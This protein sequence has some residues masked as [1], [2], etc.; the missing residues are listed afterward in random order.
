MKRLI[1]YVKECL[2]NTKHGERYLISFPAFIF[3]D[4]A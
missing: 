3:G 2:F 1:V 4:E